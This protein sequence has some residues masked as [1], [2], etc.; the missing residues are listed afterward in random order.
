L[1]WLAFRVVAGFIDR[2]RLKEFDRQMGALCGA[3]KG[4]L[5]CVA[6]TFFAVTLSSKARGAV[7]HSRSGYYIALL[8]ERANAVMPK[9]LHEVLDPYLNKLEHGLDPSDQPPVQ[10]PPPTGSRM[11]GEAAPAAR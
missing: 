5:V 10:T 2:V 6:I 3:A 4:V 1:I 8:L 7:L 11:A 9:E